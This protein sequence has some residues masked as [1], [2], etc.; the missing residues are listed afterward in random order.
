MVSLAAAQLPGGAVAV[1]AAKV[2]T[3]IRQKGRR[4]G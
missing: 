1:D 4:G 3:S 2:A